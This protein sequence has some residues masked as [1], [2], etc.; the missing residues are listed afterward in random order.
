[1]PIPHFSAAALRLL[2]KALRSGDA[3]LR[4]LAAR[5]LFRLLRIPPEL[6]R[7]LPASDKLADSVVCDETVHILPFREDDVGKL[8]V[9]WKAD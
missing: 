3:E 4:E 9:D 2:A 5:H 1:M 6:T 8:P 7:A